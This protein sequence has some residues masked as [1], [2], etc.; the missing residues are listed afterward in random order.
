MYTPE[1]SRLETDFLFTMGLFI[2]EVDV[3]YTNSM[4]LSLNLFNYVETFH[5]DLQYFAFEQ[6]LS[7]P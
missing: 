1:D 6:G 7:R 4:Y 5:I 2:E 3:Q